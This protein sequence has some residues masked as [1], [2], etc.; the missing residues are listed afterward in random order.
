MYYLHS[1]NLLPPQNVLLA[2][3]ATE[4]QVQAVYAGLGCCGTADAE[5]YGTRLLR[6]VTA[7]PVRALTL[8]S[9][10]L[11][12]RRRYLQ[13]ELPRMGLLLPKYDSSAPTTSLGSPKEQLHAVVDELVSRL[14]LTA[15]A[16][17]PEMRLSNMMVNLETMQPEK[18]PEGAHKA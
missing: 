10:P 4:Q 11:P 12:E 8:L 6:K 9:T 13:D 3:Q 2:L 18:Y 15:L 16:D 7:D 1:A 17:R 5:L 14:L